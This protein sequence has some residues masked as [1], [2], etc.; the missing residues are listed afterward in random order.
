MSELKIK[1]V[2]DDEE[3]K[4]KLENL[5]AV[6]KNNLST[7]TKEQVNSSLKISQSFLTEGKA[8]TESAKQTKLAAEA[9]L[10]DSRAALNATRQQTA[11]AQARIADTRAV[12]EQARATAAQT[13]ALAEQTRAEAA[14]ARAQEQAER[15]RRSSQSGGGGAV[16]PRTFAGFTTAGAVQAGLA[17]VGFSGVQA[18]AA[19][20]VGLTK[21]VI[22]TRANYES[23]ERGLTAVTGS[24]AKTQAQLERLREVAKLPGLGFEEA[25][26][27]ATRLQAAGLSAAES[28][29]ALRGFGKAIAQVGGGREELDG[30]VLALGQI[31][32]KSKVSAEE[33]NQ[34][35][36]RIP[37]IRKIMQE[38]FGTSDTMTLQKAGIDTKTFLH[39]LIEAAD[40]TKEV[41]GGMKNNL[42]NIKD[43][44]GDLFDE[45]GRRGQPVIEGII[46]PLEQFVRLGAKSLK[47]GREQSTI[48]AALQRI[49]VGGSV[50]DAAGL[51]GFKSALDARISG[52]EKDLNPISHIPNSDPRLPAG[53]V[54]Q[55]DALDFYRSARRGLAFQSQYE[56]AGGISESG[57]PGID[58]VALANAGKNAEAIISKISKAKTR[59][60]VE[61]LRKRALDAIAGAPAGDQAGLR[62]KLSNAY[63]TRISV[64]KREDEVN[65]RKSMSAA[66]RIYQ[67]A[68]PLGIANENQ[69][70]DAILNSMAMSTPV[71]GVSHIFAGLQAMTGD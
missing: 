29:K 71:Q 43:A 24:A 69:E 1:V 60:E 35:A 36:E 27:G 19:G 33:I 65:T 67:D 9:K 14:L 16:L 52:L 23:L 51:P 57:R 49:S 8:A 63:T 38:A 22:E 55:R 66:Q 3:A 32:S 44:F 11:L 39:V 37:Q 4:R 5:Y 15:S 41:S 20:A 28:E 45:I 46:N 61:S 54:A 59:A 17:A 62:D 68:V 64:L 18:V 47:T 56:D 48:N 34:L 21:E 25:V 42:Q 12:T 7:V 40:K 31:A 50:G 26:K 70:F 10:A 13:R 58:A 2:V 6:A 53:V 30:V